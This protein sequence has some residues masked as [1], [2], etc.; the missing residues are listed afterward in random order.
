MI[1][2]VGIVAVGVSSVMTLSAR[3]KYNDALAKDCNNMTNDCDSQ[4]LTDTHDARHEANI[5]TI[6]FSVGLAA[7]AGGV[8]VY[9]FAPKDDVRESRES[10]DESWYLAPT[11]VP[12]GGGLVL[13]GQL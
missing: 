6:I 11:V 4:G 8:I 12:N 2:G 13:G 1:G 3:S 9:L 10:R 7:I 5:A